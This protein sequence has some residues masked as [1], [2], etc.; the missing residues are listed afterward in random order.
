VSGFAVA[1]LIGAVTFLA[2][3]VYPWVWIPACAAIAISVVVIRPRIAHNWTVGPLDLLLMACAVVLLIQLIPLPASVLYQVDPHVASL[4][5]A[6]WLPSSPRLPVSIVPINTVAALAIFAGAVMLFWISRD[7]CERGGTGQIVRSLAILGI[8]ASLAA[9]V[10]RAE[11]RDLLYGFWRPLDPGARPYGPFVNRNHFATWAIMACPTIF[12][13]LLARAP[14]SRAA[15]RW[16]WR[17]A[18]FLASARRGTE[19]DRGAGGARCDRRRVVR[20]P[21][22]ARQS[23]R[24]NR[25]HELDTPRTNRH[26]A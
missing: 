14:A 3:G 7:I 5:T 19:M 23:L 2:G 22:R 17:V 25:C 11:S 1:G 20:Q 16:T 18:L 13:Y 15:A 4:R 26:L 10:Q 24:R 21:R 6:L 8:A 12:G 9:I